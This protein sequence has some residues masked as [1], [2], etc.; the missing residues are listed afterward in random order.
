MASSVLTDSIAATGAVDVR[1]YFER[2]V[3]TD[4]RRIYPLSLGN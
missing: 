1:R 2:G 4:I 3:A